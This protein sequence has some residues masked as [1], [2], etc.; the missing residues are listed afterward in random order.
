MGLVVG[1]YWYLPNLPYWD[2][3]V[4]ET[5]P[6]TWPRGPTL[7]VVEAFAFHLRTHLDRQ[8]VKYILHGLSVG[9]CIGFSHSAHKIRQ[10]G[11]NHPSSLANADVVL[12]QVRAEV[13]VAHQ[14]GPLLSEVVKRVHVSPIGLV[15]KGHNT[16]KR[17][18]IVGLSSPGPNSVNHGISEDWCSLR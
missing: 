10:R 4:Q 6:Y 9:F 8:Y 17:R 3:C 14:V 7:L 16:G 15:P 11:H 13:Q 12:D 5:R 2:S 18:M 1:Q